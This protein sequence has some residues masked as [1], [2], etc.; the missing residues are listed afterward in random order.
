MLHIRHATWGALSDANTQ[1]FSRTWGRRDWLIAHA[2]SLD[3]KLAE[4]AGPFEP[5]GSTDTEQIFCE[6][7]NRFVER[8]WRS[9][10]DVDL[11]ATREL[12]RRAQ[13]DRRADAVPD[14]RPRPARPRRSAAACRCGSAQLAPPYERI[15]FGDDDLEIDL[16]QA[17]REERARA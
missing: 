12:A 5:V 10:A 7:L 13:R 6:L 1:P 16:T 15:A 8:G 4:V 3:R 9:L 14:R 2:G 17:R 11:D